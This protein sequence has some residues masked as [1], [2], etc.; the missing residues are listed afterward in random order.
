M[1]SRLGIFTKIF[2]AISSV[3]IVPLL[4]TNALV[5][6]NYQQLVGKISASEIGESDPGLMT[7]LTGETRDTYFLLAFIFLISAILVLFAALYLSRSFSQP[8]T[9]LLAA[10]RHLARGDFDIRVDAFRGDEIGALAEGFNKMA[11]QLE[12]N[13]GRLEEANVLLENRVAQRTAELEMTNMQ[14]EAAAQKMEE[15]LL[16]KGEFLANLSHELL[17]PLH[18]ML[19]Y[20]ELLHEELYGSINDRQREALA[21]IRRG[22][23][24]LQRLVNELINLAKMEAREMT[25]S[26]ETFHPGQMLTGLIHSL[27]PVFAA[28]RLLL[29]YEV[30]DELPRL[31]T[32]RGKLQHVLYNL[33]SNAMKFTETGGVTVRASLADQGRQFVVE[34]ADTGIGIEP[35]LLNSLFDKFR[36]VGI[37][38]DRAA[39]G[40]GLGLSLTKQLV[41]TLGGEI[42]VTSE[43]GRGSVFRVVIPVA[44]G[45]HKP[46]NLRVILA[47]DDDEDLLE[48]LA[49][50]LEPAGYRVVQCRD[51][52]TGLAKARELNPYAVTLD[53]KLPQ[54]DGWAVLQELKND[55]R[56]ADIPVIVLSVIDDRARG[57]SLGVNAYI[58]KPFSRDRLIAELRALNDA[59][60]LSVH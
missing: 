3:A 1:T 20:S 52:E 38:A 10:T 13:R 5:L 58:T 14:L 54:Q 36:K 35:G 46:N 41:E 30:P 24:S 47:I 18:A 28:K 31:T 37:P 4:I 59:D 27:R 42:G 22:G 50:S 21:K 6:S 8:L 43:V 33:L 12:E 45:L 16:L 15:A 53:I 25:L 34:V 26:V 7:F 23:Q 29:R 40:R 57:Q 2:L 17:T 60:N 51:G 39:G 32:D 55:P 49:S 19:G 11:D 44:A 9:T 48:L 56:T